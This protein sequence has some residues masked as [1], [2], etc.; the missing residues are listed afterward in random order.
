MISAA[1]RDTRRAPAVDDWVGNGEAGSQME[2]RFCHL[3]TERRVLRRH[4]FEAETDAAAL[5]IAWEIFK[6]TGL[7]KHGFELWQGVRRVHTE[8]C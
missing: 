6:L 8:N 7:P 2:Y 3:D 4:E 1:R 5:E